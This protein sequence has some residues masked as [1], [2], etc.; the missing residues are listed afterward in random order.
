MTSN[1]YI[2]DFSN[3]IIYSSSIT[4]SQQAIELQ[5]ARINNL[6]ISSI[7]DICIVCAL[8]IG[9]GLFTYFIIVTLNNG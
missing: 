7:T 8:I 2:S 3:N 5:R 9:L 4:L 1:N 6:R